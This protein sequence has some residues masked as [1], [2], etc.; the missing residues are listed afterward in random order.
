MGEG[1]SYRY[2]LCLSFNPLF[3]LRIDLRECDILDLGTA[4]RTGGRRS[5]SDRRGDHDG[6]KNE[7]M[8]REA[9]NELV[10]VWRVRRHRVTVSAVMVVKTCGN[11]H[12]DIQLGLQS[13]SLCRCS[14][15]LALFS[16]F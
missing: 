16:K 3:A 9:K 6:V 2:I 11:L 4:N 10:N 7:G 1:K 8:A 15:S 13:R 12:S 14:T 5:T